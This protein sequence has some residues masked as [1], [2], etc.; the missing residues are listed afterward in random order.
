[1][2]KFTLAKKE[3]PSNPPKMV[4]FHTTQYFDIGMDIVVDIL[5]GMFDGEDEKLA[6]L[7]GK[8]DEEL[9]KML[10]EEATSEYKHYEGDIAAFL[11]FLEAWEFEYTSIEAEII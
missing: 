6:S 5:E 8:T 3:L 7:K 4:R 10:F 2:T 11:Q 1:M 9:A